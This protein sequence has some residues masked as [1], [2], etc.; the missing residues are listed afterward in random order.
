[1]QLGCHLEI[2]GT[3]GPGSPYQALKMMFCLSCIP[4]EYTQESVCQLIYVL[5]EVRF[6][7][8]LHLLMNGALYSP[9]Q[10]NTEILDRTLLN[11]LARVLSAI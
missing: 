3:M 1:M 9:H 4:F 2:E 6:E 10:G 11:R 7:L 8:T 5:V